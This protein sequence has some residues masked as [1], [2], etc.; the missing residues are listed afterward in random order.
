M[1]DYDQVQRYRSAIIEFS[2]R[3][4]QETGVQARLPLAQL[5]LKTKKGYRWYQLNDARV[6]SIWRDLREDGNIR[7]FEYVMEGTSNMLLFAKQT[8]RTTAPGAGEEEQT[9]LTG[10][11]AWTNFIY[12]LTASLGWTSEDTAIDSELRGRAP[13]TSWLRRQFSRSPWLAFLYLLSTIA[14]ADLVPSTLVVSM[15]QEEGE[16]EG[17]ATKK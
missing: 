4:F 5:L 15:P 11:Q 9:T 6:E 16:S 8:G 17:T 2:V 13:E 14:L 1:N 10:D 7:L 12:H 3:T